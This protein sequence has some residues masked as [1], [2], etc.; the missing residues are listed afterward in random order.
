[1]EGTWKLGSR[2]LTLEQRFQM[3]SGELKSGARVEPIKEGVLKGDQISFIAGGTHYTGR[4]D[5]NRMQGKLTSGK[6][7]TGW[8]A[9]RVGYALK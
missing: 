8:S 9:Q 7:S 5:G 3:I 2:E 4:V 1:V 6:K